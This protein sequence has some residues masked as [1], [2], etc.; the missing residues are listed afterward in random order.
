MNKYKTPNGQI[1]E[2]QVL[3]DNYGEKFDALI[4]DGTLK[5]VE[6]AASEENTGNTLYVTPNGSVVA[7]SML[8]KQ[9]SNNFDSLVSEGQLKKKDN[10]ESDGEDGSSEFKTLLRDNQGYK[11]QEIRNEEFQFSDLTSGSNKY[12]GKTEALD[13][14]YE[15]KEKSNLETIVVPEGATAFE[16][17]LATINEYQIDVE[18]QDAVPRLNYLFGEYGFKFEEGGSFWDGLDGMSVTAP[19]GETTTINLDPV[20]GNI[21][22]GET[23]QAEKLRDFMRNNMTQESRELDLEKQQT[24]NAEKYFSM[25]QVQEA[26]NKLQEKQTGFIERQKEYI[27]LKTEFDSKSLIFEQADAAM[28]EDPEFVESFNEHT[29]NRELLEKRRELLTNELSK[30]KTETEEIS[31]EAGKYVTFK[32]SQFDFDGAIVNALLDTVGGILASISG[33]V[34][35]V[36]YE[37]V[38]ILGMP[39]LPGIQDFTEAFGREEGLTQSKPEFRLDFMK[40]IENEN[41]DVYNA[42]LRN[43]SETENFDLKNI[44]DDQFETI[45]KIITLLGNVKQKTSIESPEDGILFT[46]KGEINLNKYS[47]LARDQGLKRDKRFIKGTDELG[48]NED[49]LLAGYEEDAMGGKYFNGV[50]NIFTD[51]LGSSDV[52]EEADANMK[53]K[54][55]VWKGIL[56]GIESLPAM[57]TLGG[58]GRK[59]P[60]KAV[61]GLKPMFRNALK[62]MTSRQGAQRSIQMSMFIT[63]GLNKEM[64]NNPNFQFVSE[65]QKKMAILPIAITSSILE[66]AGFRNLEQGQNFIG[67][68]LKTALGQTTRRTTAKGFTDIVTDVVTNPVKRASL[69]ITAGAIA[70]AETGLLQEI[71]EINIKRLFNLVDGEDKFKT[72]EAFSSEYYKQIAKSSLLEAIGGAAISSVGAIYNATT[73]DNLESISDETYGLFER[74]VQNK[75]DYHGFK[76]LFMLELQNQVING[77][78]TQ[79]DADVEVYNFERLTGAMN[80]M[81]VQ[82]D[83]TPENRRKALSLV[84]RKQE[85]NVIIDGKE[86]E[87]TVKEQSEVEAIDKALVELAEE[88][89]ED[90]IDEEIVEGDIDEVVQET[91]DEEAIASLKEK[92]NKKPTRKQIKKEKDAIFKSKTES[93]DVS[94]PA[95]DS[96]EVGEGDTKG[97]PAVESQEENKTKGKKKT[98]KEIAREEKEDEDIEQIFGDPVKGKKKPYKNLQKNSK[99]KSKNPENRQGRL[100]IFDRAKKAARFISK[101]PIL[102]Q[103][104]IQLIENSDVYNE[105]AA[106]LNSK[107]IESGAY[108]PA[109]KTIYINVTEAAKSGKNVIAH[110]VFHAVLIE[111]V[112][113]LGGNSIVARNVTNRMLEIIKNSGRLSK[114]NQIAIDEFIRKGNYAKEEVSEEELAEIFRIISENY[115]TLDSK[116]KSVV[117]R[118]ID[119]IINKLP[120]AAQKALKRLGFNVLTASDNEIVDMMTSLAVKLD[121]GDKVSKTDLEPLQKL[122]KSELDVEQEQGEGGQVGKLDIKKSSKSTAAPNISND[123]RAFNKYITMK[124][125][126]AFEGQKFVTNMYDFTNAGLTDIGGGIVLDLEG[127]KNYV[128]LMMEKQNLKIG[129]VSNIAAF[130]TKAQAETFIKS[131]VEGKANLFAPHVGT[132]DGSWQ[133]QQNIFEQL[134][135]KLLDNN[136]LTN[137]ELIESFNS[138]LES[139]NGKTAL[140]IFNKNAKN[141]DKTGKFEELKN[142]DTYIEN[143]KK[144]VDELDINNNFSPKLRKIL[145]DKIAANEKVQKH[146]GVKNKTQFAELLEDPMNVGSSAFDIIG[147]IEFDNTT[148]ETPTKPKKGD[149]DYHPSF[150]WTVKAK[151]NAIVQPTNF[152]QS[153]EVTDSYTK[154][155]KSGP[156]VSTRENTKN[157]ETSNVSSSAGSGPKVATVKSEIQKVEPSFEKRS[158]KMFDMYM[159]KW[160]DAQNDASKKADLINFYN[161]LVVEPGKK[162]KSIAR[163]RYDFAKSY[164]MNEKTGIINNLNFNEYQFKKKAEELGLEPVPTFYSYGS[165]EL[166]GYYFRELGG[167]RVNPVKVAGDFNKKSSRIEDGSE[168]ENYFKNDNDILSIVGKAIDANFQRDTIARY[169]RRRGFGR[170][171]ISD[172]LEIATQDYFK[173]MPKSFANLPGGIKSGLQLLMKVTSKYVKLI[174]RKRIDESYNEKLEKNSKKKQT[175]KG[176]ITFT[177]FGMKTRIIKS[178]EQIVD[179]VLEYMRSTSE[180][181]SA[182]VNT[183]LSVLLERD[184]MLALNP[185]PNYYNAENVKKLTKVLKDKEFAKLQLREIQVFLRNYI[186]NVIP[187]NVDYTKGEIGVLI[188][189][190]TALKTKAEVPAVVEEILKIATTKANI[191]LNKTINKIINLKSTKIEGGRFKG[192][193]ISENVRKRLDYI[194]TNLLKITNKQGVVNTNVINTRITKLREEYDELLK[195]TNDEVATPEQNARLA[196][197]DLSMKLLEAQLSDLDSA[198]LTEQLDNIISGLRVLQVEGVS[199]MQEQLRVDRLKYRR[200]LSLG[201]KEILGLDI[202]WRD[203]TFEEALKVVIEENQGQNNELGKIIDKYVK[204]KDK[205]LTQKQ[206]NALKKAVRDKQINNFSEQKKIAQTMLE[207]QGKNLP[208]TPSKIKRVQQVGA[209]ITKKILNALDTSFIQSAEDLSGLLDRVSMSSGELFGGFLQEFVADGI[210][211]ATRVF[212][213]RQI[214]NQTIVQ[215]KLEEIYGSKYRKEVKKNGI[216]EDYGIVRSKIGEKRLRQE[217]EKVKKD[218][219][220][221]TTLQEDLIAKLE[222][223]ILDNSI[224]ISQNQMYYYYNQFKDPN[225]RYKNGNIKE[226]NSKT[227]EN[228]FSSLIIN[229]PKYDS[230]GNIVVSNT[231]DILYENVKLKNE[232]DQTLKS[233]ENALTENVK[234]WADWQ[235]EVYFPMQYDHYN[236]TYQKLYRTS[237]P[238]NPYYGG[239]LYRENP[240]DTEGLSILDE[241]GNNVYFNV[242]ANSTL[243]RR[244]SS[245][246]VIGVDGDNSLLNY[247]RDME[248]FAAYGEVVRDVNKFFVDPL[249]KTAIREL[250]G[251]DVNMFIEDSIKKIA[252]KGSQLGVKQVKWLNAINTTFL[253]SR[254]GANFTLVAKQLT[255]IPTFGNDIGYGNWI[256][257]GSKAVI[258][259]FSRKKGVSGVYREM[260]DNSVVLQDRYGYYQIVDGKKIKIEGT[261]IERNIENYEDAKFKKMFPFAGSDQLNKITK[262]LMLTTMTGDKGAIIIGGIPNYLYYKDQYVK[263]NPGAKVNDQAAIDYAIIKFEKDALKTQQSYDLQDKDYYQTQGPLYRAFNMFLTTP[264]QYFRREVVATRNLYR[265]LAA[266]DRSAGK[267]TVTQNVRT[268]LLYHF[269]MPVLFQYASQGFPGLLRSLDD[270]D[271][272]ELGTAAIL[273]N[274]NAIFL[275]G[276]ALSGLKDLALGKKWGAVPD[277]LPALE[278]ITRLGV[279]YTAAGAAKTEKTRKKNM[280]KFYIEFIQLTGIPA[281]QVKKLFGNL[282]TIGEAEG[283][284]EALLKLMGYS[285]YMQDRGKSPKL[286]LTEAEKKRYIPGYKEQV[287]EAK[288]EYYEAEKTRRRKEKAKRRKEYLESIY[289]QP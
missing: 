141:A 109:N 78:K 226:G 76:K 62:Y 59:N 220:L 281:N 170:K 272:K 203:L 28:Y 161:S 278:V 172:A 23:Q 239:R 151:V 114:T 117:R 58:K 65:Q 32:E 195:K 233:I 183:S 267:G 259:A 80:S 177:E 102:K 4:A 255:S 286:K 64:E 242:Q 188:D 42:V 187:R 144:L 155:N 86:K 279:L 262:I 38:E 45:K 61:A 269:A 12:S 289:G 254:L 72:P 175:D 200:N 257:Y 119:A 243:A 264:K 108:N 265:K 25:K 84:L 184:V 196:D 96:E 43:F 208:G 104:K 201:I 180:F 98:K 14:S 121:T 36:L 5:L 11:N 77:D 137:E 221:S 149:V 148:F 156:N 10:L 75:N 73:R 194:K 139:K 238:S 69:Y 204:E 256:K 191:E 123:P 34:M 71:S 166:N 261:P 218:K 176:Y 15:P 66:V 288:N 273:G 162:T 145:N 224:L 100:K 54:W 7:E 90:Q 132:K 127:G 41:I 94:E 136:V 193:R 263:N 129:D 258:G 135:E 110:E 236:Q 207:T 95:R 276:S 49:G 6:E 209:A 150:A 22:D 40:V 241:G 37:G 21:F 8:R 216:T 284:G 89:V 287:N 97:K 50:R 159:D 246:A 178:Q 271:K 270:E 29:E 27:A 157:F 190:I 19:N 219:T 227:L 53:N 107:F 13:V 152:Y 232:A 79:A 70:E 30:F 186:R 181:K 48:K 228:T 126:E 20:F 205:G 99:N 56:G 31:F 274:L 198:G 130:N 131:A 244:Q 163:L 164:D 87:L 222:Q 231:G 192:V 147:V 217:I 168:S 115:K 57:I 165:R 268:L 143:P 158:S 277:S 1:V 68:A 17:S 253:L 93:L 103:V 120:E 266:W 213:G 134:T 92:G 88:N 113:N 3:R 63:D 167:K 124:S 223:Q 33:G 111:S 171:E 142:L 235:T 240:E 206:S 133:F 210:R 252:N 74:M 39:V 230:K 35:D 211:A 212:K 283:F 169:L 185:S 85:L 118:F 122:V 55:F 60:I 225:L 234:K 229:L 174:N 160:Q 91:T 51:V 154:Y 138:G 179:E 101:L 47:E 105:V 237:M 125:L 247:T 9:Y 282:S 153:T 24:K 82:T 140:A 52:S 189:K 83:L 260:M 26:T 214:R 46:P 285:N 280:D 245:E 112:R 182:G 116:N 16:K 67:A 44:S 275:L 215:V 250:H 199:E 146:L 251:Q 248:Y 249:V 202:E 106:N 18:E 197:I 2:E 128:P 81:G 173:V